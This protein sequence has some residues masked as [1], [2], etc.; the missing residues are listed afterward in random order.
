LNGEE[1]PMPQSPRI[2][3]LEWGAM[4]AEGLAPA[5]D[6]KLWPGGGR[7]WDW[8]ETG[9]HHVPG[10]QIADVEELLENGARTVVLTRGMDLVLQTCPETLE[11]LAERRIRVHVAETNEA[12]QVYNDLVDQGESVAGLFHS[13]C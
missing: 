3:H 9:T 7:A 13:T 1:Q 10:I 5:R 2:M 11:Y 12:S 4:E 8:R 6:M